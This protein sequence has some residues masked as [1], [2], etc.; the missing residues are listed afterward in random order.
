M[1]ETPVSI[2]ALQLRERERERES[3]DITKKLLSYLIVSFRTKEET[4]VV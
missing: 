3:Q 4:L 1:Q 2:E